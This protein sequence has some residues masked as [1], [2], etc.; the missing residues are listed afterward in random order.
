VGIGDRTDKAGRMG[1]A[2]HGYIAA[3]N[4]G[5]ADAIA[6]FFAPGAVHYF[7]QGY[8]GPARGGRAIGATFA[9]L[10]QA[11]ASRWS[12]DQILFDADHDRAVAEWT[13]QRTGLV[14]RGDEW[15]EFDP[16]TGLISEIRGYLASPPAPGASRLELEGFPYAERGYTR[17][18]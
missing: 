14:L 11:G 15:Y 12:I 2:I 17:D 6:A 8:G 13:V 7:P 9:R 5:D 1:E 3:C 18:S 16:D 10:V 4:T